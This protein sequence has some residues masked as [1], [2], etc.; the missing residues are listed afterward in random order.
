M[1]SPAGAEGTGGLRRFWRRREPGS[2]DEAEEVWGAVDTEEPSR[3]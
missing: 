1:G 2:P 3:A